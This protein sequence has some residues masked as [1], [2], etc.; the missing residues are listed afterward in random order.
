MAIIGKNIPSL[1]I[2][3][4]KRVYILNKKKMLEIA[5]KSCDMWFTIVISGH[6]G[7]AARINAGSREAI[8]FFLVIIKDIL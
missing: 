7:I 3:R 1:I 8:L 6:R 5:S 2:F 4:F